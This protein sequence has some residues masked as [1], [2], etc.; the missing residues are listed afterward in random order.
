MV[1][2]ATL[3]LL[4]LVTGALRAAACDLCGCSGRSLFMGVM[5]QYRTAF[6]GMRMHYRTFASSHPATA[7]EA[8]MSSRE[9]FMTY[10]AWARFNLLRRVQVYAFMPY[11]VLQQTSDVEGRMHSQ[12]IG[13]LTVLAQYIAINTSDSLERPV[14]HFLA[15]GGGVKAPTGST[16]FLSGSNSSWQANL[17]PGTGSWDPLLTTQYVLRLNDWGLAA[18]ASFRYATA[19][20][21][22][23]RFGN[24]LSSGLRGFRVLGSGLTRVMPSAGVQY[25]LAGRDMQ[26]ASTRTYREFS[27]GYFLYAS[28]GADVFIRKVGFGVTAM[29]PVSQH[30]AA[31]H[32]RAQAQVLAQLTWF[33]PSFGRSRS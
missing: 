3:L 18:D 26:N 4:V 27:G 21:R 10:E 1:K 17:Q 29:L 8:A 15:V 9:R 33:L 14:R 31:G 30:F 12:G 25:E 5:P 16:S 23:F 2:K 32:T 19:N 24:R 20:S 28:A 7:G 22:N 6:A 13:D 11:N